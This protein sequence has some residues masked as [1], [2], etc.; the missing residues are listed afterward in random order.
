MTTSRESSSV[1]PGAPLSAPRRGFLK[2]AGGTLLVWVATGPVPTQAQ[3]ATP[4]PPAD[5]N[6]YFLFARSGRVTVYSGKIEMGQG[7]LTSQAQI[8]AQALGVAVTSIDMV[9]GDTDTCPWDMGTFGSL[10]TRMFG[11]VLRAAAL[12][13]REVLLGLAA[14]RLGVAGDRL[15][16][17]DGVVSVVD[18]PARHLG[19]G[20]L[21]DGAA[22]ALPAAPS[23]VQRV[24]ALPAVSG[25]SLPRLDGRAKVTGQAAYT[26]DIR[27]PQMLYA[28]LLRPPMHGATLRRLDT[29]RAAALPGV[30]VVQRPDLVAVLH[31]DPQ[32][33]AQ[34]LGLLQA[35]W[36]RPAAEL[37]PERIFAHLTAN[38][39]APRVL[40]E[41][42][43]VDQARPR[44]VAVHEATYRKGYVAHAPMETHAAL[45][46]V[47]DAHATVW[48]ST[49]TPFPTRDR[50][51]GALGLAPS[52]VRV[53][54]PFLGGG[55]GG[56]SADRQAVEAARLAQITA[57]PVQVAWTREEEFFFDTFD[58]AA[59][60]T[61]AAG[62]DAEGRILMWDAMVYAAGERGAVPSYVWPHARVRVAGAPLYGAAA[63]D[64][65]LHPFGVGPW[66]GPGANMNVF[67]IE[68]HLDTV[69]AS[70]GVDP[71]AFR[72]RH[73]SD[74]RMRRVLSA[75]AQAFGWR[76]G[77]APSGR[78]V[79]VAC[80]LD[81]GTCVATMAEVRVDAR[82]G[83]VRVVRIVCAQDMGVV[84]NPDGARMQ[85]EGGLTMGLGYALSEELNFRGGEILDH[86]FDSYRI[87][88]FSDAPSIEVVLVH[89]DDLASQGGGEP[90]ITTTGA[91][92]A[93]A[94]FDATGVRLLRLPLTAPRVLVALEQHRRG[95]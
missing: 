40:A 48:A 59:V 6:A 25:T 81:A 86:N 39:P 66:R 94:V 13:A 24:A 51:A 84:V 50:V 20:E 17:R 15:T 1:P 55:F 53:I 85:V 19:Y 56:K 91:V 80:V 62:L 54:T 90:A 30:I 45:A 22:V 87:T 61:L 89:N 72:L 92:V 7:V 46:Q 32:A 73:L 14:A 93:N 65:H 21:A 69:A 49:Q 71:V 5:F 76:E 3:P 12:Q 63:D 38:S 35:D 67:A 70:L 8:A 23:A 44:C 79:G 57:R 4:A 58:P 74:A 29:A 78:G 52:A 11:P 95:A 26:A 75:A 42:G 41:H 77:A 36:D 34:A 37:D 31:A 27:L 28:R 33:A 60:V 43:D 88:H 16:V 83:A 10:S 18:D 82:T 64:G 47:R 9:L 68:S 2:L